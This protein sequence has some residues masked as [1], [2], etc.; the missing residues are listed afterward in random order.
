MQ[1]LYWKSTENVLEFF[2]YKSVG[3]L[4]F[5]MRISRKQWQIGQAWQLPTWKVA[6]GLLIGILHLILT[7]LMI[8][9]KVIYISTENISQMNKR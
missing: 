2:F 1:K 7:I 3:T 5:Q 8:T 6:Y 4:S 9:F